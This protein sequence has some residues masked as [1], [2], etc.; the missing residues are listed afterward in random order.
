MRKLLIAV[1]AVVTALAVAG[2]AIAANEYDLPKSSTFKKGKG[3]PSNPVPKGVS[4][5]YTVK[6]SAGPRGA[7]VKTYKIQFQGLTTKY[8]NKFP[9]CSFGDTERE[10]AARHRHVEVQQGEGRRRSH[11]EPRCLRHGAD[12]RRQGP[13]DVDLYANLQ[14]TLFNIPGGLSIRLDADQP[15][16][17]SQDGPFGGPVPR[18]RRST[19]GTRP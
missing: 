17:T 19:L 12:S 2:I 15:A 5:D 14:L 3:S 13:N 1:I 16:P 11:R 8:Q 7:P 18:T 4:F 9:Q 10:C 6:D